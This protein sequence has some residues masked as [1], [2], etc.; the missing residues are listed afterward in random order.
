MPSK[1]KKQHR[2]MG[3][4]A[5]N[6]EFAAEVGVPQSVGASF[7]AK[8][9][10]KYMGGGLHRM[11]KYQRGDMVEADRTSAMLAQGLGSA[12]ATPG[13]PTIGAPE[14]PPRRRPTARESRMDETR[15]RPMGFRGEEF[16]VE[17]V[18]PRKKK[19]KKGL[20]NLYAGGKVR[21]C[22]KAVRGRKKAKRIVMK[23]S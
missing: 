12:G 1:S 11:P 17:R 10:K 7:M 13:L 6:P 3:A 21:G 9:K 14:G 4:V 2:F 16:D 15:N 20:R 8:D 19:K 5:N 18:K 23:G 22:G